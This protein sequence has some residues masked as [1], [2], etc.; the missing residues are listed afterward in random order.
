MNPKLWGPGK[1]KFL[2]KT[3]LNYPEKP[4]IK[5]KND[6]KN[7]FINFKNKI[8]CAKCR[9]NY[10]EHLKKFPITPSVLE[11]RLTLV[12]W[13]IDVHNEVNKILNKK[14]VSYEDAIK[15]NSK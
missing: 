2:H 6:T 4:T 3:T 5:E 15:F 14:Q 10:V 1:W 7:F 12:H 9:K 8:P 11:S 13:L